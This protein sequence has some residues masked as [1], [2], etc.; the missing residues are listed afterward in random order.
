MEHSVRTSH[1]CAMSKPF[2][3]LDF[4]IVA[5]MFQRQG[6]PFV[7]SCAAQELVWLTVR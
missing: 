2:L 4:S 7:N 1:L 6:G 5:E 3:L